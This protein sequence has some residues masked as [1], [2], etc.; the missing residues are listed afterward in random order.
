MNY[1]GLGFNQFMQKSILSVP[2]MSSLEARNIPSGSISAASLIPPF[3]GTTDI[4]FSSTDNDTAAWTSGTI[5]FANG[6]NSGTIDA[7]NT[8][9]IVATTY[10]Y[11]DRQQLGVLQ[12][13][14]NVANATG[15]NK[16][17]IAIVEEGEA[18]KDCK[19]TPIIAAGLTV[20]GITADQIAAGTITADEIATGVLTVGDFIST[21]TWT[22]TDN[23]TATWSS[24]SII[25][26]TTTYTISGG[27]TGDIAGTTYVFLD[28]DVST[29]VLQTT[30]TAANS[31]GG[32]RRVIAIVTL[33]S[34][35][36]ECVIDVQGG[37]GTTIS[38]GKIATGTI[39]ATKLSVNQLDAVTTNTGTLTVDES[40]TVGANNFIISG[41]NKNQIINDGSNDIILIGYQLNGF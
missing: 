17:L 13:T 9:N 35:G 38:G 39:T 23:N 40:L 6:T 15:L 7:G 8:G 14:T 5:Y 36:A 20:T 22:A 34:G 16:L 19:I 2:T 4:V 10:V 1:L 28:P 37:T 30:T 32:S 11:F 24:G 41:T 25:V 3:N 26:N 12:T 27:N 21:L 29:T 18:G 31:V 33:G